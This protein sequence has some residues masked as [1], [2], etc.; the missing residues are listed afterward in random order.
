MTPAHS[1]EEAVAMADRI[2]EEQGIR[3]GKI[4]GIPDGVSV[5]VE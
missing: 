3:E 1:I 5:I 4:L 2:L